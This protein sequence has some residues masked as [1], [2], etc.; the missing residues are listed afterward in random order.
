MKKNLDSQML[1]WANRIIND[2][3]L[4]LKQAN[5]IGTTVE[6]EVGA[7]TDQ[8]KQELITS[9]HVTPQNRIDELVAFQGW[10]DFVRDVRKNPFL[11]RAQV[12]TQN[13]ICFIYLGDALFK[14][15]KTFLPPPFV[16]GRCCRFLLNNPVRAFRNAVAQSNW[17]YKKNF[18]GLEF[19]A[20]KGASFD[21]PLVH[22]EV[23]QEDLSYWQALS[24]CVAYSAYMALLKRSA[25]SLGHGNEHPPHIPC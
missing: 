23:S 4:D 2:L 8:Q 20:R 13:Y 24:R 7:I 14:N 22:F 12:I 3:K 19:W 5:H 9:S 11:T 17:R 10:M 18:S 6:N 21:E 15:L 25:N 1:I 16:T